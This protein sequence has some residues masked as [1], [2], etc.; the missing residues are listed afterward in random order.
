MMSLYLERKGIGFEVR[1]YLISIF[2]YIKAS[3]IVAQRRAVYLALSCGVAIIGSYKVGIEERMPR[4]FV[5]SI[6]K[7]RRIPSLRHWGGVEST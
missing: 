5:P 1:K 3:L 2:A 6:P 4:S 7:A